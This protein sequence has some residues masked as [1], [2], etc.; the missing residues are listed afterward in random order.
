MK[1]RVRVNGVVCELCGMTVY[2]CGALVCGRVYG[3]LYIIAPNI[4]NAFIIVC[5]SLSR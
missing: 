4:T 1:E 3:G 5:I 2:G